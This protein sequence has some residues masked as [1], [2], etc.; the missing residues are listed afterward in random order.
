MQK[1]SGK[2]VRRVAAPAFVRLEVA[3]STIIR[4]LRSGRPVRLGRLLRGATRQ[5]AVMHFLAVLELVRRRQAT[6]EQP[7]L[8]ADIMIERSQQAGE[9]VA[10]R[11]G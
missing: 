9:D 1:R 8:F 5:D 2:A 4:H 10:S 3:V 11:A 6:A 7:D